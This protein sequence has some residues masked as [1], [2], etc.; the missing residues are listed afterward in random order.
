MTDKQRDEILLSLL[1]K[2]T[3]SDEILLSLLKQVANSQELLLATNSEVKT[4]RTDLSNLILKN[5]F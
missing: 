2:A 4:I 3:S 1:K 5:Y